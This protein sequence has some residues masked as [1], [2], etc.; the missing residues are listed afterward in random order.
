MQSD[1]QPSSW[2]PASC[3]GMSRSKKASAHRDGTSCRHSGC[4]ASYRKCCPQPSLCPHKWFLC[5][6]LPRNWRWLQRRHCRRCYASPLTM[7]RD[8]AASLTPA[9][10]AARSAAQPKNRCHIATGRSCPRSGQ[11]LFSQKEGW[12][13]RLRLGRIRP[14]VVWPS[15]QNNVVLL[16]PEASP[17]R[18]VVPDR[19]KRRPALHTSR[20]RAPSRSEHGQQPPR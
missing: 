11:T 3:G 8:H 16:P 18:A 13:Q 10:S 7:G 12:S 5:G 2:L 1:H 19:T 20:G 6:L 14:V 17:A 4:E 9:Q 15:T